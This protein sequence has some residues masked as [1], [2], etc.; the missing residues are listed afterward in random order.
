MAFLM[1]VKE[2]VLRPISL[3]T[4]PRRNLQWILYSA[5][6]KIDKER[7]KI[8]GP[9]LACAEWLVKCGASVKFHGKSKT[10]EDYN[11][12]GATVG[13]EAKLAEV[14][15]EEATIMSTGFL[16]FENVKEVQKL[17]FKSCGLFDDGCISELVRHCNKS[18][19]DIAIENCDVTNRGLQ[20]IPSFECLQR[21]T[22]ID[23]PSVK[24]VDTVY[25]DLCKALPGCNICLTSGGIS[26]RS[27][28]DDA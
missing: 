10:I 26:R 12:I 24:N 22:L 21:L 18:I 8:I 5:V 17:R 14:Y 2:A 13:P 4:I 9:D 11:L 6:N 27:F 16:H 7:I 23:L 25:E 1:T 15:A 19:K 28:P 20:L 3:S